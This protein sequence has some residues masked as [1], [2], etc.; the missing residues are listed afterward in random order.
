LKGALRLRLVFHR[1]EDRIRSHIQLCWLGLLLIRVAEN[2]TGDTWRN[3]RNELDRMHL[4]TLK[5]REGR[6]AKR[7]TTT[8]RQRE[9]PAALEVRGPAQILDYE[10]PPQ[11]TNP[12][13]QRRVT[14]RP[15][16]PPA[17]ILPA[18]APLSGRSPAARTEP[19]REVGIH[20]PPMPTTSGA[21]RDR[22]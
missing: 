7:S 20:H 14:P 12:R 11:S 5:T 16:G 17:A 1:R 6:I 13:S 9:I 3:L 21:F 19:L 18:H 2:A 15:L 4:V 8:K 10:L 22:L